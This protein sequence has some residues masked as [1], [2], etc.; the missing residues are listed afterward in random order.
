MSTSITS[1]SLALSSQA[2][3]PALSP[4]DEAD[5]KAFAALLAKAHTGKESNGHRKEKA[6]EASHS[7]G[8]LQPVPAALM[9]VD[10]RSLKLSLPSPGEEP[11]GAVPDASAHPQMQEQAGSSPVGKVAFA[12]NL[13]NSAPHSSA[14]PASLPSQKDTPQNKPFE[15]ANHESESHPKDA[16]LDSPGPAPQPAAHGGGASSP[17]PAAMIQNTA[18]PLL[19]SLAQSSHQALA[20]FA[21]ASEKPAAATSAAPAHEVAEPKASP[22]PKAQIL[23]FRVAGTDDREVN[24]R[25]SQRAG[26]VQVTV[27]T[28]DS[29]LVES[30]RAHLPELSERLS[31]S[32]V[33]GE[34]L[35]PATAD[36]AESD[37]NPQSDSG[38][39]QQAF[40]GAPGQDGKNNSADQ[41][42]NAWLNELFGVQKE[43]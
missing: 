43:N 41:Q 31:Q 37:T 5:K 8:T 4:R 13:I 27:R 40:G 42:Q 2:P 20:Q 35:R 34:V 39:N 19:T 17:H 14:N 36:A 6:A 38:R 12:V 26:D 32:G 3:P 7:T 10:S 15:T 24:V 28:G 16:P 18:S 9:P 30:L 23:D 29:G 11:A 22:A 25:V 33:Q 21:H 1:P